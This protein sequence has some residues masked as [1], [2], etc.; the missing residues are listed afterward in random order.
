MSNMTNEVKKSIS[1]KE[2]LSAV[3]ISAAGVLMSGAVPATAFADA[4]ADDESSL[5]E[6]NPAQF[7]IVSEEEIDRMWADVLANARATGAEIVLDEPQPDGI[8]MTP[9]SA[10]SATVQANTTVGGIPDVVY[11]L[12]NYENSQN[13]T[14]ISRCYSKYAYGFHSTCENGTYSHVIGDGG[15]TLIINATVTLRSGAGFAQSFKL[16]GEFGPNGGNYLTAAYI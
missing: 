12:A 13:G 3:G 14:R 10:V 5:P 9:Y 7:Q 4:L 8:P 16:H 2:F 15:R 1:R 6:V 11:L